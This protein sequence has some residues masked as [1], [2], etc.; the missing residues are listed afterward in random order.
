MWPHKAALG[1]R[2]NY[3][4]DGEALVLVLGR[5]KGASVSTS[6]VRRRHE[7]S[8]FVYTESHSRQL[9]PPSIAKPIPRKSLNN[10]LASPSVTA[11]IPKHLLD[12]LK[13]EDV[14]VRDDVSL[15]VVN[16][17]DFDVV[18]PVDMNKL[19]VY[20]LDGV[21]Y[22][23]VA[24]GSILHTCRLHT[25][26]ESFGA[27]TVEVPY[28]LA[29]SRRI[30]FNDPIEQVRVDNVANSNI[31]SVRCQHLVYVLT[32]NDKRGATMKFE[33]LCNRSSNVVVSPLGKVALVETTGKVKIFS[34]GGKEEYSGQIEA[35]ELSSWKMALWQG[36]NLYVA[37][38]Q[39]L[40]VINNGELVLLAMFPAW[41]MIMTMALGPNNSLLILTSKEL[42]WFIGDYRV[43]SWEV[44]FNIE[45]IVQM[46]IIPHLN[47]LGFSCMVVVKDMTIVYTLGWHQGRP[48]SLYD[49]YLVEQWPLPLLDLLS[50]YPLLGEV[51]AGAVFCR[52]PNGAVEVCITSEM[53]IFSDARPQLPPPVKYRRSPYNLLR[54]QLLVPPSIPIGEKEEEAIRD[55]ASKM[56]EYA[57]NATDDAVKIVEDITPVPSVSNVEEMDEMFNQM[58]EYFSS[59]DLKVYVPNSQWF[60]NR[61]V[62]DEQTNGV[63]SKFFADNLGRWEPST[64]VRL[65]TSL[66]RVIL[67]EGVRKQRRVTEEA[68]DNASD[69]VKQLLAQWDEDD[70]EFIDEKSIKQRYA[71]ATIPSSMPTIKLTQSQAPISDIESQPMRSQKRTQPSQGKKKKKKKKKGGFA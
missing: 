69:S 1:S 61:Q 43:L 41:L 60:R 20:T 49:P 59:K 71:E 6:S 31:I 48:L 25:R 53:S 55:Y 35:D 22:V 64:L 18:N 52:N 68:E 23:A 42:I 32:P 10:T 3:G 46:V 27:V 67:D 57:D 24:V 56:C 29:S 8:T 11:L 13:D 62:E 16:H 44:S 4:V 63:V 37:S 21:M 47:D 70:L 39:T 17:L 50:W 51:S 2:L 5:G 26:N 12:G 40:S 9:R 36:S 58:R 38:R 33:T 66:S 30:E 14:L 28:K 7:L 54:L 45:T 65:V 19:V 15:W 34:L